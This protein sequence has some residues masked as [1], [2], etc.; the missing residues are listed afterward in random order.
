MSV[1][2]D[3]RVDVVVSLGTQPI[4]VAEFSSAAFLADLTDV[5][6]PSA[7]KVYSNLTE[8]A[9]DF[10]SN[11]KTYKY[12][13]KAFGGKFKIDKLYVIK[14]RTAATILTAVNAFNNFLLVDSTPFWV[15]TDSR[16]EA[17]LTGL[18]AACQANYKMFIHSTQ[19]AGVLVQATTNDIASVL[20]DSSYDYCLTLYNAVA[21][22]EFSEGAVA[23][24]M[25]AIPAGTST[26]EDKTLVGVPVDALNSTQRA[27]CVDK[28]V[29]YYAPI[30]GVNSVFNSKVA[31]GQFL[32]TI[33]F[34]AWLRARIGEAVYGLMKRESDAGRKVSMDNAGFSKIR[35]SIYNSVIQVGLNNGSISPDITPVVRTPAREEI[36]E[37][38]RANRVLPDVV[39][40]VLYSN[41]VHKVLVRAYVSI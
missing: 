38:D 27:S 29:A 31:S 14:Y 41:A 35:S 18:A 32:D 7:H 17:T 6:F 24:A 28:N 30:A 9:A 36:S 15:S 40:E 10:A 25:A 11:T 13:A 8:V 23:G 16:V 3:E 20:Q 34:Q 19:V 33:V 21:D 26:L 2:I 22:T 4:Q 1:D 12:A 5:A 39:V 37:A